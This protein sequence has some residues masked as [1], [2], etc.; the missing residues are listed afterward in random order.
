ML[1]HH[2][3]FALM[4]LLALKARPGVLVAPATVPQSIA[5]IAGILGAPFVSSKAE[6]SPLL[7]AAQQHQAVLASD[8]NG[9]YVFPEHQ[10]AFDGIFALIKVLELLARDGRA[11]SAIRAEIPRVAY[12]HRL[13]NCPWALKGRVMR[14]MVEMHRDETVDLADGMKVFVD[15]GWVLVLPDPDLPRYHIIV[16][17]EDGKR[18]GELADRYTAMV[19]AAVDGGAA[20]PT[21][22]AH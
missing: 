4:S 12:E 10:L 21:V 11:V 13:Q 9:A 19:Q 1:D 16:S 22:P 18:A 20:A 8:G 5:R 17:V 14:T 6:P 15:G 2:E 3:A 7:R